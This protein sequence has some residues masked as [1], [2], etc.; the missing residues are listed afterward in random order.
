MDG[1][2]QPTPRA[3][4]YPAYRADCSPPLPT[5]L[6][7]RI[8]GRFGH[9]NDA[10]QAPLASDS[11]VLLGDGVAPNDGA[12]LPS[13]GAMAQRAESA[14]HVENAQQLRARLLEMIVATEKSRR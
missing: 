10:K 2:R 6:L 8:Q 3:N 7:H 11:V 5:P 12:A 4:L 13:D 14:P 1:S 9:R